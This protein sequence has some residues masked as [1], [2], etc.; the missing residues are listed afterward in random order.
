MAK[1]QHLIKD[2]NNR[3]SDALILAFRKKIL[4]IFLVYGFSLAL[5]IVLLIFVSGGFNEKEEDDDVYEQEAQ[6]VNQIKAESASVISAT[7]SQPRT[8]TS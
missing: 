5:F 7:T 3:F 2:G 8:R 6:I 1:Y 4:N